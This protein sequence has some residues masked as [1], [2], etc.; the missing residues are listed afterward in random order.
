MVHLL[1]QQR[2]HLRPSLKVDI[3]DTITI[4]AVDIGIMCHRTATIII[5]I[6]TIIIDITMAQ[7]VAVEA[8]ISIQVAII[9]TLTPYHPRQEL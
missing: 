1:R 2:H 6:I 4:A 3:M 8:I 9:I 7:A 5:T